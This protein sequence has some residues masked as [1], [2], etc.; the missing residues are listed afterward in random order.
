VLPY[1]L[2]TFVWCKEGFV[3]S[4]KICALGNEKVHPF[5]RKPRRWR[6]ERE[7]DKDRKFTLWEDT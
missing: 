6:I 7:R 5:M 1:S 4:D 2:L 3:P